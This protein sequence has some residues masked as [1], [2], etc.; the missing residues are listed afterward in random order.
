MKQLMLWL[1]RDPTFTATET[2]SAKR[3]NNLSFESM[4]RQKDRHQGGGGVNTNSE[5]IRA[6][7]GRGGGTLENPRKPVG[8]TT[9]MCMARELPV[10]KKRPIRQMLGKC[11]LRKKKKTSGR[12]RR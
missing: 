9:E 11:H 5:P 12:G 3:W 10:Q 1:R 6:T 4:N 2:P 7:T 8:Q